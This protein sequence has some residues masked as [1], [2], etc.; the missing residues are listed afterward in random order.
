MHPTKW[1]YTQPS[2]ITSAASDWAD[3]G[4]LTWPRARRR[5]S[6]SCNSRASSAS[7]NRCSPALR[8]GGG[9]NLAPITSP[10]TSNLGKSEHPNTPVYE[11][12]M[13]RDLRRK[14][15]HA[16]E[17][18]FLSKALFSRKPFSRVRALRSDKGV[19][20]DPKHTPLF[21]RELSRPCKTQDKSEYL[22]R[23]LCAPRQGPLQSRMPRQLRPREA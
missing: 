7:S 9:A 6:W 5:S 12:L 22:A 3:K 4:K 8:R 14:S 2:G 10:R 16:L 13:R 20:A 23:R 11:N 18:L 21:S 15:R 17:S 19:P 1:H